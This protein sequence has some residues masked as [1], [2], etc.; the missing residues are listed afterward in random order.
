MVLGA[1]I[2]PGPL[3]AEAESVLGDYL[4]SCHMNAELKWTKVSNAKLTEYR[5]VLDFHFKW[6]VPRGASY[7]SL[8]VNCSELNHRRFNDG[9]PDLGFNKFVFQ[10]LSNRVG[11]VY[12]ETERAVVDMDARNSTRDVNELQRVLNSA[13]GRFYDDTTKAPFARVVYRDSKSTRLLQVA[14]LLTGA[15]AWHKNDHDSRPG[16]SEAKSRLANHAAQCVGLR[17]LGG[18]T[19]KSENRLGV[20][21]LRMRR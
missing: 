14:D 20:W 10:L 1:L 21:N 9:D 3:V 12:C 13:M 4:K 8:I 5:K 7:H 16:S 19:P 15:V 18:C 11:K 2:L 6:L 17:R